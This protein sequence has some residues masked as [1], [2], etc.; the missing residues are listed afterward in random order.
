MN[1]T[2]QCLDLAHRLDRETSGTLIITRNK[3]SNSFIKIQLEKRNMN[4]VYKAIVRGNPDWDELD[5]SAPIAENSGGELRIR[6]VI[7]EAGAPSR[8]TFRVLKH[9]KEHSLIEC[10]LHTGRTHQIRVHLEHLGYPILGDKIYGQPDR[11]FLNY[12]R[13]GITPSLREE[14]CF[15]RHA[16]HAY[17]ITFMH[18]NGVQKTVVAPLPDDMS[19]IV[20]GREPS[21]P[22]PLLN[23]EDG[24][25]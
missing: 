16:L 20:N 18:P 4:K 19:E 15:P 14:T 24:S 2:E 12:L 6:R 21:W 7:D 3:K 22:S 11:T 17:S 23:D 10:T 1:Y 8:T 25:E 9:M 5:L 13:K